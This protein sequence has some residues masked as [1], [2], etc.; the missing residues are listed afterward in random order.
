MGGDAGFLVRTRRKKIGLN[1][2]TSQNIVPDQGFVGG[3]GESGRASRRV[4][5]LDSVFFVNLKKKI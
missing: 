5:V 3:Q 2:I 1:L 4:I